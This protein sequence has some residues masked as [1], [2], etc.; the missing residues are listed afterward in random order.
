MC[1]VVAASAGHSCTQDPAVGSRE[2]DNG[3]RNCLLD[4]FNQSCCMQVHK[5]GCL[6][7]N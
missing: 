7:Q 3:Y 5:F 1:L 6:L 4:N 2:L